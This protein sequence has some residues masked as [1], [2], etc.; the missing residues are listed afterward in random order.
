[1]AYTILRSPTADARS[2][3]RRVILPVMRGVVGMW[4]PNT[5]AAQAMY[6]WC[7]GQDAAT[8]RGTPTYAS[9]SLAVSDQNTGLQTSIADQNAMTFYVVAKSSSAFTGT[10]TRPTI[11]GT[12]Q[13]QASGLAG[14]AIQVTGTPSAAPAATVAMTAARDVGTVPTQNAASIT[15]ANFNSPVLLVGACDNDLDTDARRIYDKTNGNSAVASVAPATTRLLSTGPNVRIGGMTSLAY[16]QLTI[17]AAVVANVAHTAA[18]IEANAIAIRRR[19]A[20]F[21]GITV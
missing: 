2:Y 16:G 1:M 19:M 7:D 21:N 3:G 5:T 15:V 18:E 10:T 12:Y 13:S 8:E 14:A 4:F 17:Y 20:A 11:I 6:N 9:G